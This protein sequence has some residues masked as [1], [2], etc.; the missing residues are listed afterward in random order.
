MSGVLEFLDGLDADIDHLLSNEDEFSTPVEIDDYYSIQKAK[1]YFKSKKG[2]EISILHVNI[3]S[4]P[5]NIDKLTN[6]LALLDE[7]IDVIGISETNITET[8]N[9]NFIAYLPHYTFTK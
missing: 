4:L 8:V 5:Q 1:D 7:K 6:F 9:T 3:R 2:N